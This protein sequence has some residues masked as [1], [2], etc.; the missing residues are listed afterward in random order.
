VKFERQLQEHLLEL[1]PTAFLPSPWL[2]Y[3]NC[4]EEELRWCQPDGLIIDIPHSTITL[5][6]IKLKHVSTAW[7]QLQ[8]LYLPVVRVLFGP[9]WIYKLCEAVRYHDPAEPFPVEY[10]ILSTPIP[11]DRRTF[12]VYIWRP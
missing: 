12:G 8:R 6:E 1:Y 9:R 5:I 4:D 7:W 11:Y 10:E 2:K 3:R